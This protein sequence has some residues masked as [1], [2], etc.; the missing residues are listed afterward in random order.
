MYLKS[1]SA[2]RD[3]AWEGVRD[4]DNTPLPILHTQYDVASSCN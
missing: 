4:A 3:I 1:I 2:Y